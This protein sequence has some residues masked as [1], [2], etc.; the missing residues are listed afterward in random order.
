MGKFK[1]VLLLAVLIALIAPAW[2]VLGTFAFGFLVAPAA[3]ISAGIYVADGA[4]LAHAPK[5]TFG[6]LAGN[7]WAYFVVLV[8]GAV[9]GPT[10][11]N[12]FLTLFVFVLPAVFLSMYLDKVFDLSAWLTGWAGTLI[13]LTVP[14]V[15]DALSPEQALL[16]MGISYT[17]GV[18]VVGVPILALHG[19]FT[20]KKG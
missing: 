8:L 19:H 12:L 20:K 3:L 1:I 18:W 15:A 2:A 10:P 11:L 13:V 9:G 5:I 16:Q 6:F 7:F 17:A 4:Q 14:L